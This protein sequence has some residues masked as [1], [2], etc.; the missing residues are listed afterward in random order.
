[1]LVIPRQ[2]FVVRLG[3]AKTYLRNEE[4]NNL[5]EITQALQPVTIA[6]IEWTRRVLIFWEFRRILA[7]DEFVALELYPFCVGI[8]LINCWDRAPVPLIDFTPASVNHVFKHAFMDADD[9][10]ARL[11]TL[12]HARLDHRIDLI[13]FGSSRIEGKKS[14]LDPV[15]FCL[16]HAGDHALS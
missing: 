3:W 14:K 2:R 10:S 5:V 6:E 8:M 12:K 16:S 15:L 9:V 1:M 13:P 11:R 4:W 7:D